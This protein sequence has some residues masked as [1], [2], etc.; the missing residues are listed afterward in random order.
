MKKHIAN[1]LQKVGFPISVKDIIFAKKIGP[2]TFVQ[3]SKGVRGGYVPDH[4]DDEFLVYQGTFS[5]VQ[6]Y[7]NLKGVK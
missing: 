1:E 6:D 7:V 5:E 2:K 3:F 4:E